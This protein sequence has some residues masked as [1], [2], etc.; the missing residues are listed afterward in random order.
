MGLYQLSFFCD[1]LVCIA[2]LCLKDATEQRLES[3]LCYLSGPGAGGTYSDPPPPF[4]HKKEIKKKQLR[5]MEAHH[6]QFLK[7][8]CDS[9]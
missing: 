8:T 7:A 4:P 1:Q 3:K 5:S 9:F 2:L 6:S